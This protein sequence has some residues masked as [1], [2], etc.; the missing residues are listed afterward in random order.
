MKKNNVTIQT[1]SININCTS[2]GLE[3]K[4]QGSNIHCASEEVHQVTKSYYDGVNRSFEDCLTRFGFDLKKIGSM[5]NQV[6]SFGEGTLTKAIKVG[7]KEINESLELEVKEKMTAQQYADN[8]DVSKPRVIVI[9]DRKLDSRLITLPTGEYGLH[10]EYYTEAQEFINEVV[11][12]TRSDNQMTVTPEFAELP[13][14]AKGQIVLPPKRGE[15]GS[16]RLRSRP[17]HWRIEAIEEA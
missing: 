17:I 1:P 9:M 11:K 12:I 5:Y 16:R 13:V 2:I 14:L 3:V 15:D 7:E 4:I 6:L 8:Y 10:F